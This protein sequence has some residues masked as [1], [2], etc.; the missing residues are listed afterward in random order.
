MWGVKI[1]PNNPLDA[2][3]SVVLMKFLRAR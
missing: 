1:D 2:K 3:V